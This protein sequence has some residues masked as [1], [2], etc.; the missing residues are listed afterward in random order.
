MHTSHHTISI[1]LF[2][3]L[4]QTYSAKSEKRTLWVSDNKPPIYCFFRLYYWLVFLVLHIDLYSSLS[5]SASDQIGHWKKRNKFCLTNLQTTH[6]RDI[7]YIEWK[8]NIFILLHRRFVPV[9]SVYTLRVCVYS[10][11]SVCET[12]CLLLHSIR[13]H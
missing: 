3:F 10:V 5:L 11:C 2:L 6:S 9:Q 12:V 7:L 13:K 4:F 8:T 1:M